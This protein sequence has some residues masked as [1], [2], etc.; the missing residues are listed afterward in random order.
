MA[1]DRRGVGWP[2]RTGSALRWRPSNYERGR[3]AVRVYR[4]REP[5]AL[6]RVAQ[7]GH[8]RV[9]ARAIE[10]ERIEEQRGVGLPE[11]ALLGRERR[12]LLQVGGDQPID[13]RFVHRLEE[14]EEGPGRVRGEDGTSLPRPRARLGRALERFERVVP[15]R[16]R[17]RGA[18]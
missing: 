12:T 7:A 14:L 17:R 1:M 3:A 11:H 6:D 10:A 13:A 18:A 5:P 8:L 16:R 4:R 15:G 9:R 2:A